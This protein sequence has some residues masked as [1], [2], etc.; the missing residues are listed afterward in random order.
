VIRRGK[1]GHFSDKALE[2]DDLE[3][4]IARLNDD[5]KRPL[6]LVSRGRN[7]RLRVSPNGCDHARSG[8]GGRASEFRA[9]GRIPLKQGWKAAYGA[10]EPEPETSK[11]GD[12]EAEQM[13]PQLVDG[14]RATLTD[15][16][17][18]LC[19]SA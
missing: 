4:R 18:T 3:R 1:S 6:P 16:R 11:E 12:A 8:V 10:T 17:V 14:E 19:A 5:E 2:G 15:P 9:V 7:A 13:P